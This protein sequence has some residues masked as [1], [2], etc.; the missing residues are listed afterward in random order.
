MGD[1]KKQQ[2]P[3]IDSTMSLGDHL[4]ELRSRI[5][6]ALIGLVAG[7]IICLIWGGWI[8]K[9]M[10]V[11]Y[12]RIMGEQAR[13]QALSPTDGFI[14][15]MQIALIGGLILSSPWVFYQLWMFVAAG[16]YPHERRYVYIATPLT[17]VLFI[18]G[19]MFF[20]FAVVLHK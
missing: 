3:V 14:C 6:L 16:L 15:Y 2:D 17:V 1:M 9:F 10:E 5:I 12:I 20:M 19:A 11:P 8:V 4:E 18:T 7:L 13:L